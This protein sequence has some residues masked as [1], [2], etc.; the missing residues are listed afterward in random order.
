MG[1]VINLA[2]ISISLCFFLAASVIFF[3]VY[4]RTKDRCTGRGSSWEVLMVFIAGFFVAYL[5]VGWHLIQASTEN[6]YDFMVVQIFL[7]TSI[8]VYVC[9]RIFEN[10]AGTLCHDIDQKLTMEREILALASYPQT[11]PNPI[12]E[13]DC[14]GRVVFLND[15]AKRTFPRLKSTGHPQQ[16]FEGVTKLRT[17]LLKLGKITREV[18]LRDGSAFLQTVQ[19]LSVECRFRIYLIDI[20]E[21]RWAR[22]ELRG[23]QETYREFINHLPVG[24]YRNTPGPAGHFLEANDAI[25]AIFEADSKEQFM[26]VKVSE[27]YQDP[28]QRVVFSDLISSQGFVKDMQLQMRTLKGRP[29]TMKLTA[30]AKKDRKGK[31]LYFDGIVQDVT[32]IGT[33]PIA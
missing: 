16:V 21:L 11:N 22:E 6:G 8:F 24:V 26:K 14:E 1:L 12:I 17:K 23:A 9:A 32:S 2:S 28:K 29:F 33:P 13:L 19:Y 18:K 15:S 27:L 5:L 20:T 31:I 3:W 4:R 25:A 7:W 10:T 30:I